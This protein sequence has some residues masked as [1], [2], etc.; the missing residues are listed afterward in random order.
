MTKPTSRE[1]AHRKAAN[2]KLVSTKLTDAQRMILAGA[3]Q[4]DDGAA[5]L[6]ECMTEKAAHKLAAALVQN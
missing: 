3:A 6:A 5:T 1:A 2:C 4:R